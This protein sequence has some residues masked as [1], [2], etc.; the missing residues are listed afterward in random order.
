VWSKLGKR[1]FALFDSPKDNQP[2]LSPEEESKQL[3]KAALQELETSIRKHETTL[4]QTRANQQ[5]ILKQLQTHK[6]AS[7]RFYSDAM[8][9]VK[10]RQDLQAQQLLDQ[11]TYEDK[12]VEQ[13][14]ALYN[15]ITPVV[16]QLE[17]QLAKM[18]LQ[19]QEIKSRELIMTA[20]L[21]NAKTQKE[22]AEYLSELDGTLGGNLEHELLKTE[23][24]AEII[25]GISESDKVLANTEG[26]FLLQQQ[27]QQMEKELKENEE[28][29]R[30]QREA[31]QQKRIEQAFGTSSE[32]D[33]K[34]AEQQKKDEENKRKSLEQAIFNNPKEKE[35]LQQTEKEKKQQALEQ[36]LKNQEQI[37]TQ[38]KET[39]N[40][41]DDTKDKKN[42]L[43]DFFSEP[44]KDKI[45][46]IKEKLDSMN[47]E[48]PDE[49]LNEKPNEKPKDD[50]QKFLD[51]FFK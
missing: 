19:S 50:K 29:E 30:K 40:K 21:Q 33:K 14:E 26:Q 9:A 1:I 23:M 8:L 17:T 43:D 35:L 11:K 15:N 48:K 37:T 6:N 20:R 34:A 39:E 38:S 24:E 27:L 51:D 31:N 45:T 49:K 3:I 2:L 28:R 16:K 41:K 47:T 46:E 36:W 10:K 44:K 25:N 42:L 13:Y 5:D 22:V 4:S 32:K 7:E 18:R 12:Q